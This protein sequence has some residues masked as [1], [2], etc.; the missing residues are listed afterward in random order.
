MPYDSFMKAFTTLSKKKIY[1]LYCDR[2]ATSILA[3]SAMQKSGYR[4][5]SLAGGIKAFE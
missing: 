4:C 3:V 5:M 1:I 2:G